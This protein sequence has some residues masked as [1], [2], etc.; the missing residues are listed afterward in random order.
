[1]SY[2]QEIYDAAR[3]RISSI[4]GSAIE[5]AAYE[6]FDISHAKSMLQEQIAAAGYEMTRP[7]VVF[8]PDLLK[9]GDMWCALLGENL[10]VGIAGFGPNPAQAMAAFDAA[11]FQESGSHIIDRPAS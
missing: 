4:D 1:M 10:Q 5:R 3:S 6:A 7:C 9:D 8:K 11:W 2:S